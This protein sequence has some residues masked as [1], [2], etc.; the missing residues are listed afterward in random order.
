MDACKHPFDGPVSTE[1][2][3]DLQ[4]GLLDDATAA[5]LRQ[6]VRRDPAAAAVLAAL[7]RVRQDLAALA[8]DPTSAPTVPPEVSARLTAALRTATRS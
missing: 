1:L 6:R 5:R 8:A 3:A 2:L 7:E 4:A